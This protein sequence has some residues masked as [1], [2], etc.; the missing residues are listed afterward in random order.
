MQDKGKRVAL[1]AM[2]SREGVEASNPFAIRKKIAFLR[3]HPEVLELVEKG[4][5]IESKSWIDGTEFW[6]TKNMF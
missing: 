4:A 6:F 3:E 1:K 2:F 5:N